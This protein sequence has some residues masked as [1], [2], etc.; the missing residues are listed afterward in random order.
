MH[1]FHITVAHTDTDFVNSIDAINSGSPGPNG[2][3]RIHVGCA[4][5]QGAKA[6]FE[7]FAVDRQHR[8]QQKEL[9]KGKGHGVF[10][11]QQPDRQRPVHHVS[12]GDIEEGDREQCGEEQPLLQGFVLRLCRADFRLC[13]FAAPG[14]GFQDSAVPGVF[15]CGHDGVRTHSLL[16]IRDCHAVLQQVHGHLRNTGQLC[17]TLF[18][19]GGAS[20]ASH[21]GYIKLFF[22]HSGPSF[23]SAPRIFQSNAVYVY[24]A[25]PLPCRPHSAQRR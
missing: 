21:T 14:G 11:A 22:F 9:G 17:H 20:G 8:E 15:H 7:V 3:Q 25:M 1:Q 23:C 19:S 6:H 18:Y 13:F 5:E 24:I 2:N 10:H 4:V 16:I 12:H